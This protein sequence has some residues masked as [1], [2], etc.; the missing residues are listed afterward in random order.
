[1]IKPIR[2]LVQRAFGLAS[3][4]ASRAGRDSVFVAVNGKC[5]YMLGEAQRS[6]EGAYFLEISVPRELYWDR[7]IGIKVSDE[8]RVKMI[9]VLKADLPKRDGV[10]VKI[11]LL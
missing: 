1:M 8:E 3:T 2:Y 11:E 5:L 9:E 7:P 6:N 4:Y 10:G